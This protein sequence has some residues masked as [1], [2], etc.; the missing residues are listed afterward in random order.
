M[1]MIGNTLRQVV[2]D[3]S[4][5]EWISENFIQESSYYGTYA[6]L[7]Q[8]DELE[9]IEE[10]QNKGWRELVAERIAP[11][12]PW[13]YRIITDPSRSEFLDLLDFRAKGVYLDVGSGW[14]QVT[15]PLSLAGNSIA[16]DLTRNRLDILREIAKQEG[17][18]LGYIQGNFLTFP[19]KEKSFDLIVFNGSLE[20]IGSGRH[21]EESIYSQQLKALK[22]AKTMLQEGG[23]IYI[24][25]ENSMGAKYL[26]GTRDDHTGISHITYLRES[27]M[28]QKYAASKTGLLPTKTYS[29]QEYV[30]LFLEAGLSVRSCYACFPDYKLIRLMVPLAD[31]NSYILSKSI[32][33]AEH[34]GVDGGLLPFQDE[35]TEMYRTMARNGVAQFFCPSYSFVLEREEN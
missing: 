16:F 31:L 21:N 7:G 5:I 35:L 26:Q 10:L 13:L 23:Q 6:D 30:D 9:F 32:P 3:E 1:S 33:V 20:W 25:I 17:R 18:D 29:Y 28:A 4:N 34:D 27:A 2:T 11:T 19:F 12:S 14:G 15:L 24:G 22:K 8:E